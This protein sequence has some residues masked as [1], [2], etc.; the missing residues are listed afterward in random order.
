MG[1]TAEELGFARDERGW[2]KVVGGAPCHFRLLNTY[3][4]VDPVVQLQ[5]IVWDMSD[6]DLVPPHELVTIPETGGMIIG[7][8]RDDDPDLAGFVFGWGGFVNGRPRLASDMMGVRPDLRSLGLGFAF[9]GDGLGRM[10]R[11]QVTA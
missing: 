3:R 1:F 7:V 4:E 10:Q 6:R 11:R 9:L 8:W 5:Q 2:R